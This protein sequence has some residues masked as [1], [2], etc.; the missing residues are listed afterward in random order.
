MSDEEYVATLLAILTNTAPTG[1]DPSDPYG[2]ADDGIDRF[3]G[4]GRDVMVCGLQRVDGPHGDELEVSFILKLP[5][6]DPDWHGVPAGGS[7]RVPF[8]AEWRRLSEFDD[9]AAYAPKVA[10]RVMSAARDH[11]TKHQHEGRLVRERTEWRTRAREGLP[12]RETQRQLLLQTLAGEGEA[13]Q[14]APD[15]FELR[16]RQDHQGDP[17]DET[18]GAAALDA[19]PKVIT[20]VLTPEEWEEVLIDQDDLGLYLAETLADPDP[21]ERFVVFHNGS[22]H[23]S[24]RAQLPPV[25]GRGRERAWARLRAQH[26]L[27]SGDGWYAD[28]PHGRDR[29]NDSQRRLPPQQ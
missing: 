11:A 20:F 15:R 16:L 18:A 21:D 24:T 9:P 3:D 4:F 26:P 17:T 22:L 13:S 14:V 5:S 12:D 29:R 6:G 7:V 28:D 23:R 8:D 2:E 27:G 25:Q 1:I 10:M 19:V